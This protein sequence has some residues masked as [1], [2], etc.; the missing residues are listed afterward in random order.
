MVV[1][2]D[3]DDDP[4]EP[5]YLRHRPTYAAPVSTGLILGKFLP[6]H[7][8]HR[9]LAEEARRQADEVI[10]CLLANSAEPIPVELRHAWLEAILPWATVRSTVADHRIDY[11]D[12][13]IHDLWAAT[14]RETIGRDAVDVLVTSEPAY[15]DEIARRLGARHILLDPDR[16]HVPVSGSAIRADPASNL[17]WLDEPVRRW[18]EASLE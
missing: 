9:Y 5:G 15:G 12:P 11:A 8:G 17:Q 2:V 1:E 6:P 10:V 13:A 7:R 3:R 18:Y 4:V 16:Q 14:I